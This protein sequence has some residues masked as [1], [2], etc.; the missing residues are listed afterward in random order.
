MEKAKYTAADVAQ[1]LI[2]KGNQSNTPIS[3]LQLQK[4]LFF[5]WR[6]YYSRTKEYLFEEQ[7]EA[8]Q[9]GHVVPDVYYEY[10]RYSAMKLIFRYKTPIENCASDS[11]FLTDILLRYANLPIS[12][13]VNESH[14][15]NGSWDKIYDPNTKKQIPFEAIIQHD[16][17]ISN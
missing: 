5:A 7:I 16:C 10:S 8:W 2:D 17:K 6:D 1:F 3:N 11:N 15:S 4:I 9:Y 14:M 12:K 13:L